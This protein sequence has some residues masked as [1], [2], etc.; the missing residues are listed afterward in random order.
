[1]LRSQHPLVGEHLKW[2]SFGLR[3]RDFLTMLRVIC[4]LGTEAGD[5]FSDP[6]RAF[7]GAHLSHVSILQTSRCSF[8]NH[9]M[10]SRQVTD[11]LIFEIPTSKRVC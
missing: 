4:E 5:K 1:M 3:S 9:T 2:K 8:V 7:L 10:Q 11:E 6:S